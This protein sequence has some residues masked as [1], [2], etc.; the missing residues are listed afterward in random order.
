MNNIRLRACC[1]NFRTVRQGGKVSIFKRLKY[2]L[3][4]LPMNWRTTY[5]RLT[6]ENESLEYLLFVGI[7][8]II[9][10]GA[11]ILDA[12]INN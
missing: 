5:A 9:G 12:F 10:Q 6:H 1:V 11:V 3:N 8:A 7:A 2:A 4:P